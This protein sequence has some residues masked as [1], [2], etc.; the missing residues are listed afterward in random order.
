[1]KKNFEF[2]IEVINAGIS[3][4]NWSN[5]ETSL[6]KNKLIDFSPDLIVVFDSVTFIDLHQEGSER[7]DKWSEICNFGK[8]NGFD[9]III[10]Q[11]SNGSGFRV[12]TEN[13]QEIFQNDRE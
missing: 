7:K 4:G 8:K 1:M 3:G 10:L 9:T 13:D 12:L 6:I 5:D 11:P 2:D